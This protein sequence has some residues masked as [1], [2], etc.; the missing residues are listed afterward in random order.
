MPSPQHGILPASPPSDQVPLQVNSRVRFRYAHDGSGAQLLFIARIWDRA[1]YVRRRLPIATIACL[2]IAAIHSSASSTACAGTSGSASNRIAPCSACL[3]ANSAPRTADAPAIARVVM[4]LA[5]LG[6]RPSLDCPL[7]L[8]RNSQVEWTNPDP[9]SRGPG[10]I[11]SAGWQHE[12]VGL[13]QYPTTTTHATIACI[14]NPMGF[15]ASRNPLRYAKLAPG[16][17]SGISRAALGHA[18]LRRGQMAYVYFWR[19]YT[20][21]HKLTLSVDEKVVGRAGRTRPAWHVGL[22]DGRAVS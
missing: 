11:R 12:H 21:M 13:L 14:D 7:G 15:L 22:A 2:S 18:A 3:W 6:M 8:V 20:Y 5:L 19:Y 1:V 17:L 9:S 16:G 10:Q 4:P